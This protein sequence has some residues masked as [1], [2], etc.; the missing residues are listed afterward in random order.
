MA[1]FLSACGTISNEFRTISEEFKVGY[2]EAK[3]RL[4]ALDLDSAISKR[5]VRKAEANGTKS[6]DRTN[7]TDLAYR[8]NGATGMNGAASNTDR[9]HRALV[10]GVQRDLARLGYYQGPLDGIVGGQTLGAVLL[11]QVQNDIDADGE[12]SHELA[13]HISSQLATNGSRSLSQR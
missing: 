8:T 7:G 13:A 6:T 3:T 12:V 11:Y 1:F 5:G 9:E 2:A 4:E 10:K